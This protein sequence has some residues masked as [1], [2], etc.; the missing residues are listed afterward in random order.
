MFTKALSFARVGIKKDEY[1]GRIRNTKVE[2]KNLVWPT[3][4]SDVFGSKHPMTLLLLVPACPLKL[5]HDAYDVTYPL[6]LHSICK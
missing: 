1:E 5:F 6:V 2:R 3:H 4:Q